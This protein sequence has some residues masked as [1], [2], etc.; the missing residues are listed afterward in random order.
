M[1]SLCACTLFGQ[2]ELKGTVYD[3]TQRIPLEGVSVSSTS[4]LGAVTDSNGQ[5]I[6][7]LPST[8][9]VYFSYLGKPTKPVA[10]KDITVPWDFNMSLK[11]RSDLLPNVIV[12]PRNYK[13]DSIQNR[14]DYKGIFG[15]QKPNPLNTI[16][17]G[18]NGA[19]GM[20]PNAIINMFRFKRNKRILAFQN[21][22]MQQEQDK[23]IDYRYNRKIVKRL[24]GLESP[25][26][27]TFM[28]RYRP[29]YYF[30]QARND[31]ELYQYI[32]QA[33]KEFTAML[34][35]TNN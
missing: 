24:T 1:V 14:A 27:D 8:D 10:V 22:L 19:V 11:I 26:L 23:Y 28:V 9:S 35:K 13:M 25:L 34:G 16:N 2:V 29:D 17:V 6:L 20:D 30:V 32:F 5:Y 33:G 18:S 12:R 31:L 4:G 15:F 21:R 7:K 3:V